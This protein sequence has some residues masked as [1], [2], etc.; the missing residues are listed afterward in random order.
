MR[1]PT[2]LRDAEVSVGASVGVAVYPV[3]GEDFGSLLHAAD[4]DM[5]SVKGAGRAAAALR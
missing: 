3:D 1:V 2:R 4:L 5:Y